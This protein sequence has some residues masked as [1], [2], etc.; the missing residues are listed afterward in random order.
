VVK[1]DSVEHPDASDH[2]DHFPWAFPNRANFS[3]FS[4]IFVDSNQTERKTI[5]LY[6]L[7]FSCIFRWSG[8]L[9][10]CFEPRN[11]GSALVE[12]FIVEHHGNI[13][14]DFE[15][16]GETEFEG[17]GDDLNGAGSDKRRGRSWSRFG[18]ETPK[19]T[20]LFPHFSQCIP[21]T[22][23]SFI[24]W[25]ILRFYASQCILLYPLSV[26]SGSS[27]RTPVGVRVPASAPEKT[28]GYEDCS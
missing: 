11:R 9:G 3:A 20:P 10:F 5:L 25:K 1:V 4:R 17:S 19:N 23:M 28:R 15:A 22:K 2:P 24:I 18:Q 12:K 26:D 16:G 27:G 6:M 14:S 7:A 13:P 8:R 21:K